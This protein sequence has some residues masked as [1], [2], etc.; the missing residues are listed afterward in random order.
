VSLDE[1][2]AAEGELPELEESE[3]VDI[4][5]DAEADLKD[6]G[7]FIEVEDEDDTGDDVSGLVGGSRENEDEI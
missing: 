5:E 3:L 7:T 6:E 1:V 4:D 2:E